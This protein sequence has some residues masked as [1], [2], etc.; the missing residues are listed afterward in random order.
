MYKKSATEIKQVIFVFK[1][2]ITTFTDV[3]ADNTDEQIVS[4]FPNPSKHSFKIDIS[5]PSDVEVLS[6]EGKNVLSYKSIK[7][8][9]FGENLPTGFYLV[10]IGNTISKVMKE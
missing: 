1:I 7:N 6:V 4:I 8:L 2:K 10:K 9:E 3:E 5:Q